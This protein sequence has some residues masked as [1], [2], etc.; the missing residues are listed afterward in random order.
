LRE[1]EGSYRR[2]RRSDERRGKAPPN[3]SR[4]KQYE[5]NGK[6]TRT[7]RPGLI[8]TQFTAKAE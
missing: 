7:Y 3:P 5:R 6:G 8:A 4:N 1:D 2:R